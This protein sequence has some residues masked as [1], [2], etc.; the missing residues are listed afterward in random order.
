MHPTD[1]QFDEDMMRH[2]S[3]ED[4]EAAKNSHERYMQGH[5]DFDAG[6]IKTANELLAEGIIGKAY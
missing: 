4:F 2:I 3:V 5:R 6:K 1:P